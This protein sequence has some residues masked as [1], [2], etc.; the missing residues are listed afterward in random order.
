MVFPFDL[1]FDDTLHPAKLLNDVQLPDLKSLHKNSQMT[2]LITQYF[3]NSLLNVAFYSNL[4]SV[5][6]PID[7]DTTI[8]DAAL[9][10]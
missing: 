6:I 1:S 2:L 3:I 4:L 5:R 7:L 8:L 10:N 9:L